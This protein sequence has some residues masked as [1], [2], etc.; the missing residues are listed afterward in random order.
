MMLQDEYK[1]RE[2]ME[3][4]ESKL[5]KMMYRTQH[6][7]IIEFFMEQDNMKQDID[8]MKKEMS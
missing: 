3:V 6:Y 2:V 4:F 5:K 7:S 1:L 8:S